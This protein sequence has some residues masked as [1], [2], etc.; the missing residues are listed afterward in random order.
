MFDEPDACGLG[1]VGLQPPTVDEVEQL[2]EHNQAHLHPA[3]VKVGLGDVVEPVKCFMYG[4]Q[5]K[6]L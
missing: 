4:I 6:L 3:Q 5:Y 1:S 2:S